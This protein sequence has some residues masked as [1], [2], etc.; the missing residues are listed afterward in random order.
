MFVEVKYLFFRNKT[1]MK[2]HRLI[3]ILFFHLVVINIFSQINI[4][5]I[6]PKGGLS[7]QA[8]SNIVQD[9]T[10]NM[11]FGSYEGIYKYNGE[12]F[13]HYEIGIP[14]QKDYNSNII[15]SMIVDNNNKIWI[16]T[17]N[18]LFCSKNNNNDEFVI[19]KYKKSNSDK[20][21]YIKSLTLDNKGNIW[22]IDNKTTG[23]LDTLNHLI[24]PINLKDKKATCLY[25]DYS[26]KGYFGTNKGNVYSFSTKT[27]KSSFLCRLKNTPHLNNSLWNGLLEEALKIRKYIET[28]DVKYM[29]AGNAPYIVSKADG[30]IKETGTAYN[31]EHYSSDNSVKAANNSRVNGDGTQGV[32]PYGSVLDAT[33]YNKSDPTEAGSAGLFKQTI[34]PFLELD[35]KVKGDNSVITLGWKPT[36]NMVGSTLADTNLLNLANWQVKVV[37]K[38]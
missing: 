5:R 10:G 24:K 38:F 21:C 20:S 33:G 26:G 3:T 7:F 19:F 28:Q 13:I 6:T 22:L 37:V 2:Y 17:A 14:E 11:W 23:K 27:Y 18:G 31:I 8:F 34:A 12:K 36:V 35:F 9:K 25:F 1:Y 32:A 29:L 30:T 4:R 15:T 16:G